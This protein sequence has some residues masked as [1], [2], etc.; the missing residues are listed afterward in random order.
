M[1][2]VT[3]ESR[4]YGTSGTTRVDYKRTIVR[5]ERL[6]EEVTHNTDWPPAEYKLYRKHEVK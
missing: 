3:H 2:S 4:V 6:A 5:S 1:E